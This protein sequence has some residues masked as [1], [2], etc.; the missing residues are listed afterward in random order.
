V[1]FLS[2]FARCRRYAVL[3]IASCILAF[4]T[5]LFPV[6]ANAA[7]LRKYAGIV[8]DAKTGKT[9]YS[10]GADSKRYP[11]SVSKVMTL[12][13][14]F[15]ELAAGRLKLS[16][17]LKV[18][19]YA[20]SAEPS[21]LYLKAGTSITVE[22]AIKALVTKSANDVARVIAENISGSVPNFAK[23]MTA[24]ARGLGMSKTTYKNP[25][26][27]PN[28]AQVTTVRDQ[29]R[30]G[31]A[32]FQHFPQYYGYFKTR[33]FRYR[34]KTYGNHNR[35]LGNV[36][37]VDGMKTG[38]IRAAGFNLLTSARY[39]NRHVI[40][41]GF[42]F[43]SSA[44]R[45]TK[46]TQLINKYLPKA[47]K[48]SYWKQASIP[49]PSGARG[50][51]PA[52][53]VALNGKPPVRP[54]HLS[55]GSTTPIVPE[56]IQLASITVEQAPKPVAPAKQQPKTN[57][58]VQV[59]SIL[60]QIASPRPPSRPINLLAG[61]G[62]K[63]LGVIN[64]NAPLQPQRQSLQQANGFQ[65]L[66]LLGNL[67]NR[68]QP[69]TRSAPLVPQ[70]LV[71]PGSVGDDLTTGAIGDVEVASLPQIW[72][73]Q[74]GAA[75]DQTGADKL[76]SKA[77]SHLAILKDYRPDVQNVLRNGQTFYRARY[78]GF[79]GEGEASKACE[80][81]KEKNISCLALPG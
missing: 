46:V 45:N 8:V 59:A 24:T 38:Y 51:V 64:A 70:G 65:P 66:S 67:I 75:K 73:V 12:Y 20:A 11:A 27:L 63:T 76:I 2:D 17:K 37:G 41:V 1:E 47:R 68:N 31:M 14:V 26:G 18:S 36:R 57:D 54:K 78:L 69:S 9:L 25:S 49:K 52:I 3:V 33:S 4:A 56:P 48:G 77:N 72:T 29:A 50:S 79:T 32:V 58:N 15:E 34:G 62:T 60:T 40:A 61:D 81:L 42:G 23:R 7:N 19:K 35:L 28:S 74:V 55:G 10:Y 43:D 71:P 16:S 22:N 44:S 30:L 5:L 53:A 6:E 21:K 80:A 13:V 39:G